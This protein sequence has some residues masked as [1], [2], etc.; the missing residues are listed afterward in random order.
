[1]ITIIHGDDTLG[2]YQRLGELITEA[3]NKNLEVVQRDAGEINATTLRQ[4]TSATDLF[5]TSTCL[6]IKN[7]LGSL[8]SK[9]KEG[10][11]SALQKLSQAEILLYEP[12]KISETTLKQLPQAKIETINLNPLIFKF[13]DSLRPGN[14]RI[15]FRGW[16]Q[17]LELGHQP[18]YILVMVVRQVRLLIQA[19]S[20]SSY[21][22]LSAYPKRL[23][24]SQANYFTL[25]HL[26]DLHR[27]LYQTDKRL[28]TGLSAL[29]LE[30]L[31]LQFFCLV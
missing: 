9:S 14:T 19:K 26:L 5:G 30:Q 7:L 20:G 12:K 4:E 23:V 28:K 21:L 8:K 13:L 25:N 16:D 6:V 17:L 22:K 24:I 29:P 31:L 2:S 18:E 10:L 27:E 11:I 1:M 15:I 3:K